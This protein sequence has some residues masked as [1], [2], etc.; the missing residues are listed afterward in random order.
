[1]PFTL[2]HPAAVLPLR[3]LGM[4]M[5]ALVAG[6]MAPDVPQM[7]GVADGRTISHSATAVVTV[8]LAIGMVMVLLWYA[9]YRRPLVDLAPDRW[10]TRLPDRIRLSP[11]EWALCVPAVIVGA[12][13]HVAWDSFTHVDSWGTEHVAPL[14]ESFLGVP[15]YEWAQ[16][17]CSVV[18]FALVI[19]VTMRYLSRLPEQPPRPGPL[20]GRWALVVAL[21]WPAGHGHRRTGLAVGA[22]GDGLLRRDHHDAGRRVRR[23]LRL[24]VVAGQA[25]V[26]DA[27]Q[28]QVDSE[29]AVRRCAAVGRSGEL[30]HAVGQH[31]RAVA[32]VLTGDAR[33]GDDPAVVAPA[34][35]PDRLT[36]ENHAREARGEATDRGGVATQQ[37]VGEL[38]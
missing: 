31:R 20:V 26:A 14:R 37:R 16:H 1:M 11:L 34:A 30:E 33:R 6:A 35:H 21:G 13:T 7:L 28:G 23:Q 15:A 22:R 29:L 36:G 38:A 2:A 25:P 17:L 12:A 8:D 27:S 9:V 32:L 10:R 19:A 3:G 5:T 18:G 24:P 4:P